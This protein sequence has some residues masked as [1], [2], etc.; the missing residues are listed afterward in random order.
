ML[1]QNEEGAKPLRRGIIG[2]LVI[3]HT[4]SHYK[5]SSM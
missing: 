5:Y 4:K 3:F 2:I 1:E